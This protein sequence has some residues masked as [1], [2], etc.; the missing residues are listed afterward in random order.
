MTKGPSTKRCG[1]HSGAALSM[2]LHASN[3]KCA[4]ASPAMKIA[5]ERCIH[6]ARGHI[7]DNEHDNGTTACP[8]PCPAMAMRAWQACSGQEQPVSLSKG[9]CSCHALEHA[10]GVCLPDNIV[11]LA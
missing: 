7:D 6:T 4:G 9:A 8:L 3:N 10:S 2:Q 11:A 5:A 1:Q